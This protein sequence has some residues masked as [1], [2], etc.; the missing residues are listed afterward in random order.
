MIS[1]KNRSI[2]GLLL[3]GCFLASLSGCGWGSSGPSRSSVRGHVTYAGKPIPKGLIRFTP[4]HSKG[5]SGPGATADI[6]DGVYQTDSGKGVVSGPHVVVI[7]GFSGIEDPKLD[8]PHG[9]PLF[10]PYTTQ[11]DFEES[12]NSDIDFEVLP[13][14]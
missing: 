10:Q 12:D 7:T 8:L 5:N 2:F 9:P 1:L 11:S 3:V 6:N 4:D 14:K 13:Q